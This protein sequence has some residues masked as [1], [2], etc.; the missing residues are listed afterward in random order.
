M[1]NNTAEII[2]KIEKA[3][4]AKCKGIYTPEEENLMRNY[5]I[6]LAKALI[7]D[8]GGN[9]SVVADIINA[10][11]PKENTYGNCYM[12]Q[13]WMINSAERKGD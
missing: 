2:G 6:E 10:A 12:C 4:E 1:L 7:D 5:N 11:V 3:L 13:A 8:L 9:A